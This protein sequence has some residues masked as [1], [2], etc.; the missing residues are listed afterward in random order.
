MP[1]YAEEKVKSGN[2]EREESMALAEEEFRNL[3]PE[4]V[5][6]KDNFLF[7]I[8][9]KE[10]VNRKSVVVGR[11]W[12]ALSGNDSGTNSGKKRRRDLFIYDFGINEEFRRKG[13][14]TAALKLLE[15][16]AREHRMETMSLHV[17]GQNRPARS[18]YEKC[19]FEETNVI[20]TKKL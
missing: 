17:F 13:Y 9:D 15:S 14:A 12:Y 1:R 5:H 11:I 6:M 4:G 8:V 10:E 7:W 3:L 16:K 20:M 18:L 2:W 19:G